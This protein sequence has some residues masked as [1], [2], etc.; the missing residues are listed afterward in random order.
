MIKHRLFVHNLDRQSVS[1]KLHH[2]L[3]IRIN[4][5]CTKTK[6]TIKFS[7]SFRWMAEWL[8]GENRCYCYTAGALGSEKHLSHPKVRSVMPQPVGLIKRFKGLAIRLS[9]IY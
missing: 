1:N 9:V 7:A 2:K 8:E 3:L 4:K 5:I 6:I